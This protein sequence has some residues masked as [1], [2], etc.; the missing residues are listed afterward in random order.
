[1]KKDVAFNPGGVLTD[2]SFVTAAGHRLY[3]TTPRGLYV[4]DVTDPMHPRIE[5]ELT[6]GFLRNPH[7]IAIQFRYAF[8]TDNDGRTMDD[9]GAPV[10]VVANPGAILEFKYAGE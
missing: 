10:R 3:M 9:K 4:I 6:N 8:V 1:M 5:G 7:C 2:A